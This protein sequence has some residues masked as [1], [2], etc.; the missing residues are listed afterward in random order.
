MELVKTVGYSGPT[1]SV[2]VNSSSM[3]LTSI[4]SIAPKSANSSSI[5]S[6]PKAFVNSLI[7]TAAIE[8]APCIRVNAVL[9]GP[10]KTWIMTMM[11]LPTMPRMPVFSLCLD[12]LEGQMKWQVYSYFWSGTKHPLALDLWWRRMDFGVFLEWDLPPRLTVVT[13][14]LAAVKNLSDISFSKCN[15]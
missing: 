11:R 14:Q 12:V 2:A 1:G 7:Q 4:T 3:G 8:N 6:A 15:W 13:V 5:C 9:P 10:V